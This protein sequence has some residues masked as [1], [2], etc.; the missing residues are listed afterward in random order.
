MA[1]GAEQCV[2]V[3]ISTRARLEL[4]TNDQV[5]LDR[6]YIGVRVRPMFPN[7]PACETHPAEDTI[8]VVSYATLRVTTLIP[9]PIQRSY[10]V[11]RVLAALRGAFVRCRSDLPLGVLT[12][13]RPS[14]PA[15]AVRR[16]CPT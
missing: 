10:Y 14:S 5:G 13:P 4:C 3:V 1:E 6:R 7:L 8:D 12:C 16:R 15:F 2:L 11:E 9:I